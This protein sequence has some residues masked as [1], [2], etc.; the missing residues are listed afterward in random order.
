MGRRTEFILQ[1]DASD[2]VMGAVLFQGHGTIGYH[3]KQFNLSERNYTIFEKEIFAVVISL[4]FSRN[5][6]QG[7]T[8][9]KTY[10][11]NC[12][13]S[14]KIISKRIERWKLW[15]PKSTKR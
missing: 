10:N 7:Y 4:S 5:L 1:N 15:Y 14:G 2:E 6:I 8:I 3:S 9:I 13:F 12:I 11:R